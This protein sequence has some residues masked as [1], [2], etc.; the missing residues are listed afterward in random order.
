[1]SIPA[2]AFVEG[3]SGVPGAVR[4]GED[5]RAMTAITATA[6]AGQT[7][8]CGLFATALARRATGARRRSTFLAAIIVPTLVRHVDPARR[9]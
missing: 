8:T 6:T 1:M 9:P 2:I 3:V 7:T 4:I 5:L